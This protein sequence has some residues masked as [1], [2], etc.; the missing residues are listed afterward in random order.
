M[1]DDP[2]A[3][4][5]RIKTWCRR[6]LGYNTHALRYAF[7]GYMAR[8]GV[9]AQ[10]VARITGHVKLDYILHYTQRVRAEEIL[11]KINLS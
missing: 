8:R 5:K 2:E 10:L 4:V 3:A 11:E 1:A 6:F 9:A 7:I